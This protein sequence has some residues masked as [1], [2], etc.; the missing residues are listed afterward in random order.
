M[1]VC[2]PIPISPRSNHANLGSF[3]YFSYALFLLTIPRE[4]YLAIA[5]DRLPGVVGVGV[6]IGAGVGKGEPLTIGCVG[7]WVC[8]GV[9]DGVT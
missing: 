6:A 9:G 4:L 1:F 2:V 5:P 7:A 8:A 3:L